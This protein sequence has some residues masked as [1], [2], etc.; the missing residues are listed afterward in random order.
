[1]KNFFFSLVLAAVLLMAPAIVNAMEINNRAYLDCYTGTNV[2]PVFSQEPQEITT[3]QQ[4]DALMEKYPQVAVTLTEH[5]SVER[6]WAGN[7][8]VEQKEYPTIWW[9]EKNSDGKGT[10]LTCQMQTLVPTAP[11]IKTA[12]VE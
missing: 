7:E 5:D 8:L 4:F 3:G 12:D 10:K 9:T 1:M 2:V 11:T 6:V